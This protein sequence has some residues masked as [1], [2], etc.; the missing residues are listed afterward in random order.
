[1][2][3]HEAKHEEHG[4]AGGEAH[5]DGHEKKGH[6]GGHGGGAHGGG[7]H[8]EHAGAPEWLISFADNV[9][10]LMGFFV[11]LLAMN[12]KSKTTGGVGGTE[13]NP[14][15]DSQYA[16]LLIGIREAFNN[17]ISLDS[18]DPN[19][20]PLIKRIREKKN[21]PAGEDN[22][23][24]G[25]KPEQQ[26]IRPTDFTNITGAVQFELN[27]TSVTPSGREVAVEIAKKLRGHTWIVE[28]RGHCSSAEAQGKPQSAMDLAYKRAA[29]VGVLLA[30]AGI[31]WNQLRLTAAADNERVTPTAYDSAGHRSN[32]RAEIIVTNETVSVDPYTREPGQ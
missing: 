9:A 29:A 12:M 21:Q 11:I 18:K 2:A 22:G 3:D 27:Q 26:A 15:A 6:G 25:D 8:E 16:D 10:L 31:P 28:V 13:K 23:I 17:P 4:A 7:S 5:G 32:Q 20:A 19:D 1:M 24:E 14:G 30:E